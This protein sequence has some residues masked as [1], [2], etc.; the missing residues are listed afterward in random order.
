MSAQRK[1]WTRRASA[2]GRGVAWSA[3]DV[4]YAMAR[5]L[6][7]RPDADRPDVAQAIW[8]LRTAGNRWLDVAT[9]SRGKHR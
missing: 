9:A 2:V 8:M 4:R 3:A 1:P 5:L 6:A 7:E